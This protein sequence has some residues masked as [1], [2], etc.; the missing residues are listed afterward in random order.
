MKVLVTGGAGFIGSHVVDRLLAQHIETVLVDNLSG[1]SGAAYVHPAAVLYTH[2]IRDEALHEVFA[3]ERPDA[4]IHLAAQI[5]VAESQRNPLF[6]AGVNIFG[7]LSVLRQC[8]AHRVRKV[9]YASSAAV[10]G[11]PQ[12]LS[13]DENHPLAPTSCY[14]VSKSVPES[15]IRLFAGMYGLK[16]TILRFANVYGP[17]QCAQGEAGVVS[18]FLDRLMR[19]ERPIIYGDGEQ[20]RDFVYVEDVADAVLSAVKADR[21]VD[22]QTINISSGRPTSVN[23]LVELMGKLTGRP[24]QSHY[25]EARPGDIVHSYLNNRRALELM[26][27]KPS[28]TLAMGLEKTIAAGMPVPGAVGT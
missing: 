27:W 8:E 7:T 25:E 21:R 6:D 28:H 4:V 17:R 14:G 11:A 1:A 24:I 23:G 10:Y 18:V 20:T 26:Q 2:D 3:R 22:N 15:Y 5:N 9:V 12:Y 16:Y 13:I 19:S